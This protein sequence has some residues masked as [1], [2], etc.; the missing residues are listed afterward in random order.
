MCD[1]FFIDDESDIRIAIEQSFELAEIN[2]RFFAS[3][4]GLIGDKAGWFAFGRG[5]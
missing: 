5:D 3:A 1:V 2:A 4:R